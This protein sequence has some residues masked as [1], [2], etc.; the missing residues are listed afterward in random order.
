MIHADNI[1]M[2]FISNNWL[3]LSTISA[4]LK[5]IAVT[6]KSVEDNKISTMFSLAID[7]II[8]VFKDRQ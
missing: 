5:G 1:L 3:T 7:S 8:K 2:D 6:N 4:I